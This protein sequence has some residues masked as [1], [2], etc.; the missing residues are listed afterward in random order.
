MRISWEFIT[1]RFW[2]LC[3]QFDVFWQKGRFCWH[4][5]QKKLKTNFKNLQ[6][7]MKGI[8]GLL[9]RNFIFFLKKSIV[10]LDCYST[11]SKMICIQIKY[12]NPQLYLYHIE[13]GYSLSLSIYAAFFISKNP[14]LN[15]VFGHKYYITKQKF[16]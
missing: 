3:H 7:G 6:G 2:V 13:N 1:C 4:V 16:H 8:K 11:N 9:S 14:P 15:V 10:F 5:A 12:S